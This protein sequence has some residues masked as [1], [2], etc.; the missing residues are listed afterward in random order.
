MM[1][2]ASR[3]TDRGLIFFGGDDVPMLF[4]WDGFNFHVLK[5]LVSG[6]TVESKAISSICPP[7]FRVVC[8]I[9]GTFLL[10]GGQL[11]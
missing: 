3:I 2:C 10:H 7:M 9:Y 6:D 1:W 8:R 5:S 4:L 11:P